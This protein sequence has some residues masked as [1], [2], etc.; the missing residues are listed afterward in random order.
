MTDLDETNAGHTKAFGNDPIPSGN[1]LACI[2]DVRFVS[3]GHDKYWYLEIVFGI[4]KGVRE[5]WR[6]SRLLDPNSPNR[7][8]RVVYRIEI[9]KICR[10]IN[11][12]PPT[13]WG[14]STSY[15]IL[16]SGV[17]VISVRCVTYTDPT[18]EKVTFNQ[19]VDYLKR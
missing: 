19:V 2:R 18:G 8:A 10:A 11:V 4:I 6:L 3:V 12:P 14:D 13:N 9:T 5:K 1:Y 17:L 16:L 15:L 7:L